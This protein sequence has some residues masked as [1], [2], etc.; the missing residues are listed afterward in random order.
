[1][2]YDW[3]QVPVIDASNRYCAVQSMIDIRSDTGVRI[4]ENP[5]EKAVCVS[6][7]YL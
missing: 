1:M 5:L 2:C 6:E 3:F 7:L 4:R